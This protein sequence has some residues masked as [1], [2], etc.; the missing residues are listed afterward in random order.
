MF[1]HTPTL[2]EVCSAIADG[3]LTSTSDG[4]DYQINAL[5]LRRYFSDRDR[6]FSFTLPLALT[7]S[8]Q[9]LDSGTQSGFFS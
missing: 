4:Q 2:A 6:P 8:S 3:R 5:E 1:D 7:L 9:Q